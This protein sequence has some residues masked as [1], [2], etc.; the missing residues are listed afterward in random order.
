M[1]KTLAVRFKEN[2]LNKEDVVF[3]AHANVAAGLN[4]LITAATGVS[5]AG[6]AGTATKLNAVV[7]E[8]VLSGAEGRAR[9]VGSDNEA[10]AIGSL[11]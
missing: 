9:I 1:A 11:L 2:L 6:G 5:E 10:K 4:V 8:A 7:L 3:Q